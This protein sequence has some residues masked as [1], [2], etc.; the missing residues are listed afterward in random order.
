MSED[1]ESWW[2]QRYDALEAKAQALQGE[3]D[4]AHQELERRTA[5]SNEQEAKWRHRQEN[6]RQSSHDTIERCQQRARAWKTLAKRSRRLAHSYQ[7]RVRELE[8]ENDRLDEA[9][10]DAAEERQY[11][12][13][14]AEAAEQ[15]LADA[16]ALLEAGLHEPLFKGPLLAIFAAHLAGQPAA[17]DTSLMTPEGRRRWYA[18]QPA[19]PS[20][21]RCPAHG[22]VLANLAWFK[23]G[24]RHVQPAAPSRTPFPPRSV[25]GR[26]ELTEEFPDDAAP[27]R[28]EDEHDIGEF[29]Y[30]N[31]CKAFKC[32][33]RTAAGQ[34]VLDAMSAMSETSVRYYC[35]KGFAS[36]DDEVA[37][38]F[39]AELARRGL[40]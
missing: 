25:T 12:E 38:L 30:C 34:A 3:R 10:E 22:A 18:A 17:L 19:A 32:T 2:K 7:T 15:K 33:S 21:P 6:W 37:V 8:A 13:S 14:R 16:H 27:S 20:R 39:R 1:R 5:W 11:V 23:C 31:T 28:T 4:A 9:F 24:C 40:T 29:G 26:P 35:S 36:E